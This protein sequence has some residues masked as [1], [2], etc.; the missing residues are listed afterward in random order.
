MSHDTLQLWAEIYDATYTTKQ[1]VGPIRLKSA[2]GT[3]ELDGPGTGAIS[4]VPMHPDFTIRALDLLSSKVVVE[5]WTQIPGFDKRK[6]TAFI[7]DDVSYRS[8]TDGIEINVT[9]PDVMDLLSNT[10]TLLARK[11]NNSQYDTVFGALCTLAGWTFLNDNVASANGLSVRFDG[12]SVLKA[13]QAIVEAGGYHM[14]LYTTAKTLHLGDLGNDSGLRIAFAKGDKPAVRF[15]EDV[16]IAD[17]MEVVDDAKDLVNWV[18]PIGAGD[19]DS[20][21]TLEQAYD[22]GNRSTSNGFPYDISRTTGPDGRYIYYL[23]DSTSVTAYGTIQR[24][25]NFKQ[26]APLGTSSTSK[27]N[28]SKLLYDAAAQWLTRHKDP[29]Q[30]IHISCRNIPDVPLIAD[31]IR[32]LYVETLNLAG[33]P[34]TLKNINADYW[35]VKASESIGSTGS[36][37]RLTVADVDR[38]EQTDASIVVGGLGAIDVHNVS[39]KP[40]YNIWSMGPY[41][42]YSENT[43]GYTFYITIPDDVLRVT[44]VTMRVNT[45][46]DRDITFAGSPVTLALSDF[47]S[48][49]SLPYPQ[50]TIDINST[51]VA[52]TIGS[53]SSAL[54]DY[55]VDITDEILAA[56]DDGRGPHT[57]FVD[58]VGGSGGYQLEFLIRGEITSGKV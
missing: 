24:R 9:G 5:I 39:F 37:V 47:N 58:T 23:T 17:N 44:L 28:A 50:L 22:D 14:R 8:G 38:K 18:L 19:G 42:N 40:T 15:Q 16:L 21:I 55:E 2:N 54:V 13:L 12:G 56:G 41:Q 46:E 32:V 27:L 36:T 53:T 30:M 7:A 26:I 11:Y 51:E 48:S 3:Q 34:Y 45:F 49:G 31:K 35:V 43:N 6:V 20:A 52:A 1:G 57:I 29:V 25:L 10:S 33:T 4:T